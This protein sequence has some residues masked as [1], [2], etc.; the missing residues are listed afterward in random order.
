MNAH[1]VNLWVLAGICFATWL[2]SVIT[3]DISV[4]KHPECR[5]YQRRVSLM[6]PSWPK[7]N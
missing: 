4:S 2:N 5:D 1:N 3:E 7:A 6:I